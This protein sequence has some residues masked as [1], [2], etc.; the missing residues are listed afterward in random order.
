MVSSLLECFS[1]A[2]ALTCPVLVE[3]RDPYG[4]RSRSVNS[5]T[6]TSKNET[7]LI[8]GG[9]VTGV[10]AAR[11]LHERGYDN[12]VIVEARDELGGRMQTQT[13][14]GNWTVERGPNW[15][16]GTQTGDGPKNPILTLAEKWNVSTEFND[17]Y[18]S[19]CTCF[20]RF[21]GWTSLTR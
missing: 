6:S 20:Y 10:I 2:L 5:S 18:G 3:G 8:L 7:I 17:L 4:L 19:V 12:F 16:Q 13:I 21:A 9:G 14:G 15:V 1:L 11:T